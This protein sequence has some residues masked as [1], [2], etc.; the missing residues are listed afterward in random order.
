MVLV[1]KPET[2]HMEDLCIDG[3]IILIVNLKEYNGRAC[4][5]LI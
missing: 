3:K 2:D 1:G 4:T 5:E